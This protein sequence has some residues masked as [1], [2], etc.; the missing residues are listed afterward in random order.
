MK[1]IIS[2]EPAKVYALADATSAVLSEIPVG[3]LVELRPQAVGAA[4]VPVTR[5]DGAHGYIASSAPVISARRVS[6]TDESV[7]VRDEPSSAVPPTRQIRRGQEFY[8]MDTVDRG[9][10]RWV[11]VRDAQAMVGYI[12]TGVRA[13]SLDAPSGGASSAKAAAQK[14]MLIGAAWC[15]GGLAVT[16]VTYS[17]ASGGGSYMIAWGPALFGGIQFL[18]GVGAYFTAKA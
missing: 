12:P 6:L 15:V 11:R 3:E 10:E 17:M 8:L 16:G 2:Q 13:V 9:S 7:D 18:R 4:W 5:G 1:A 14:S